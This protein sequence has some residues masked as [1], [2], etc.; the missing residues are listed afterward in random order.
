[1][2]YDRLYSTD[3]FRLSNGLWFVNAA[4][5][6]ARNSGHYE[7]I[8]LCSGGWGQCRRPQG[9]YRIYFGS[10]DHHAQ[11]SYHATFLSARLVYANEVLKLAHQ[12][13]AERFPDWLV[14]H[15]VAVEPGWRMVEFTS[16]ARREAED[17][18]ERLVRQI[19]DSGEVSVSEQFTV[20]FCDDVGNPVS[21]EGDSRTANGDYRSVWL[22]AD[23]REMNETTE[24][25]FRKMIAQ[26]RTFEP[27]SAIL[28]FGYE[29]IAPFLAFLDP[30][31]LSLM[32][33]EDGRPPR[34]ELDN[35]LFDAIGHL[36]IERACRLIDQGANVNALDDEGET[37]LTKLASASRFDY[38]PWKEADEARKT[39]PDVSQQERI[40]MMRRLLQR[41]ADINLFGY[42]GVNSL[43]EAV[44]ACEDEVVEFLLSEGAD[45]NHSHFHD[46]DPEELSSAL[47]YAATDLDLAERGSAEESKLERIYEALKKAGAAFPK[48][49]GPDN[50]SALE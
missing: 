31:L 35:E 13:T 10:E 38:L 22:V 46:E 16:P 29:E 17:S 3:D 45:P 30:R 15:W 2:T 36:D 26:G 4:F 8:Q 33:A 6:R 18:C 11:R 34:T 1:M 41:G 23:V 19:T 39:Q 44:L 24:T 42:E 50:G 9:V 47:S 21:S 5:G 20:D 14:H 37:P 43:T 40:E 48:R 25:G 12:R 28:R 32:N 49:D 27:S 7:S